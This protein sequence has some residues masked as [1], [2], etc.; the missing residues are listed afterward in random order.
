MLRRSERGGAVGSC[1]C[2]A[3]RSQLGKA[4]VENL[5]VAA[6]GHEDVCG[7]DVTMDD[8]FGV[9]GVKRIGHFDGHVQ[10]AFQLHRT[11]G[12]VVFQR[13]AIKVFHGDERV[14]IALTDIVNRADVGMVQSGSSLCFALKSRQSLSIFGNVIGKKFQ[15]DEAM[16]PRVF[17]FVDNSHA[18]AA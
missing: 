16:K 13:F 1:C 8:A 18:A 2:C 9:S 5:G 11:S 6:L 4:E 14:G 7:F 15:C 12:D 17:R 10:N 3:R